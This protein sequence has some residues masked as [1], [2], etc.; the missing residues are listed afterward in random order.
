MT[1]TNDLLTLIN[2]AREEA[3][4]SPLK[5]NAS[6]TRAAILQSLHM[7]DTATLSHIGPDDSSVADRI[8]CEQYIFCEAAEN[9]AF[10]QIPAITPFDLWMQSKAHKDNILNPGFVDIGVGI[11]PRAVANNETTKYYW[12]ITLGTPLHFEDIDEIEEAEDLG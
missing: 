5:L 7:F 10:C 2:C 12:T 8:N 6:L 4:L 1:Q 11:A 9:I 3:N